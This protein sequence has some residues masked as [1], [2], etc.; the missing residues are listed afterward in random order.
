MQLEQFTFVPDVL[1]VIFGMLLRPWRRGL[2]LRQFA[3]QVRWLRVSCLF[4]RN[5]IAELREVKG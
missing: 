4:G 5:L 3:V 2:E 1:E